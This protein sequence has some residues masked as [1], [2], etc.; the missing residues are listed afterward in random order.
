LALQA[1]DA[2]P[3]QIAILDE[4]SNVI[5]VNTGWRQ[6]GRDNGYDG[7]DDFGVGRN[8]LAQC[9]RADPRDDQ[10]IAE[11]ARAI[12]SVLQGRRDCFSTDYPCH[13]PTEQRWFRLDVSPYRNGDQSGVVVAHSDVTALHTDINAL[14]TEQS[15]F[16]AVFAASV[17][18]IVSM[19]IDGTI[20]LANRA[21]EEMFG[22]EANELEGHNVVALMPKKDAQQHD[23]WVRQ[24]VE[25]GK[26]KIV[27]IGRPVVAARKDGSTFPIHLAVGEAVTN[28]ARRFTGVIHDLGTLAREDME[29]RQADKVR[30]L[31]NVAGQIAHD[32]NNLL[33]PIRALTQMSLRKL[34]EN[35]EVR[36]DLE[37]V[38]KA[39]ERGVALVEQILTFSR[40]TSI[41]LHPVLVR[42]VINEAERLMRSSVPDTIEMST[43]INMPK[44]HVVADPELI[45]RM[46]SNLVSNA[47]QAIGDKNGR[48]DLLLENTSFDSP[49]FVGDTRLPSGSYAKLSILDDGAGIDEE[50]LPRIFD[51]LFTTSP[52]GEG[53][54]MG[55]AIVH[56]IVTAHKGAITVDSTPGEGTT[57]AVY[58]PILENL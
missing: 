50:T 8:Y 57:F 42:D 56:G 16:A 22:Y 6:F 51:P 40:Q 28:G 12:R 45:H 9:D 43:Q 31:G 58:L 52:A 3:G 41:D 24:Y 55:L 54:G 2:L 35:H 33:V 15:K 47:V 4:H 17:C 14:T 1:F 37:Q 5:A 46:I 18:A 11:A 53:T 23:R 19:E 21:A 7:G 44:R 39:T 48:I 34:P 36:S 32:F 20:V 38:V 29:Q 10:S 13:S 25:T 30:A 27:G 49:C 26:A